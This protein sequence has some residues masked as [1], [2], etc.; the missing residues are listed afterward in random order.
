M[1]YVLNALCLECR[2]S[3]M[4]FVL[5]VPMCLWH[6][7]PRFTCAGATDPVPR[8]RPPLPG[9]RC[10]RWLGARPGTA[11]RVAS[12]CPQGGWAGQTMRRRRPPGPQVVWVGVVLDALCLG[13]LVS[14]M[15][16]VLDAF[17]L[18]CLSSWMSFVL[19]AL[20]LR[21]L[22]S[23]MLAVVGLLGHGDESRVLLSPW[24]GVP[25]R[26]WR[27]TPAVSRRAMY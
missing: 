4:P 17:R 27:L 12:P 3:W 24:L 1:L 18:G 21:C 14:W 16:F 9:V 19:D 15:P 7:T 5:A 2:S 22:P 10:K 11:S 26:P 13:C 25:S 6:L 8:H 20:G 23:W